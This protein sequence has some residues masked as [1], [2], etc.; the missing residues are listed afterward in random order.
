MHL[1]FATPQQRAQPGIQ[2][3]KLKRFRQIVIG[4]DVQPF[5]PI[6]HRAAGGEKQDGKCL[7]ALS[8]A[9]HHLQTIESRH[10]N[11]QHRQRIFFA[12]QQM[13]GRPA[14][15]YAVHGKPAL[16]QRF[17]QPVSQLTVIFCQ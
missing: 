13:I 17:L 3:F 12:L 7:P 4:A 8:Q 10:A 15:K 11:I 14:I 16:H 6:R 5:N 1:A 9:L 2:L